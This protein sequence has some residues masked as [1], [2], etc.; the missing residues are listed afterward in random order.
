MKIKY[1]LLATIAGAIVAADQAVKTYI[2]THFD[3]HE[4]L[5]VIADIFSITYVRNP[6]AAFGFLGTSPQVF[7]EIFFLSMP[8]VALLI[9]I[10]IMRTV[11]DRD[12][13]TIVSLSMVFGGAIGNYI[14][15]LRFRYV[16]DYLDF[17]LGLDVIRRLHATFLGG[18]L[19]LLGIP[20]DREWVY[21]AFNIADMAIVGGVGALLYIEFRKYRESRVPL[22][23][24]SSELGPSAAG[25]PT[26]GV[27]AQSASSPR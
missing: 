18:P 15:R 2:H 4:S 13:L 24:E 25:H 17:H 10:A 22:K 6:G 19:N 7:R 20:P 27:E 11:A 16:I 3:L 21:P 8:P 1:L 14:D 26:K 5:Q 12:R 9:I 23:T